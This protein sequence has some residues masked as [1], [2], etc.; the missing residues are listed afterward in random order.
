[1]K[2]KN[3]ILFMNPVTGSVDSYENWVA[4]ILIWDDS[5]MTIAEQLA[6]LVPVEKDQD[7]NWVESDSKL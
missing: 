7:G 5:E 4:D 2:N 6:T 3:E 1:M